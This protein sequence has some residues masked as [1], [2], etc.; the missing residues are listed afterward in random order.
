MGRIILWGLVIWIGIGLAKGTIDLGSAD[1]SS[2]LDAVGTIFNGLV[3]VTFKLIPKALDFA[4]GAIDQI[5]DNGG[6][7]PAPQ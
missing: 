6:Q 3:D 4:Q 2:I 1:V 5:P 7:A